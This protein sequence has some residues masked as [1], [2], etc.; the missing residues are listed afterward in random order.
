MKRTS[1][2]LFTFTSRPSAE[3][4]VKTHAQNCSYRVALNSGEHNQKKIQTSLLIY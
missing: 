3:V 1:A 4:I 2:R